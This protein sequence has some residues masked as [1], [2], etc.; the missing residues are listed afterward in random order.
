MAVNNF[1]P[2]I[3]SET[4]YSELSNQCIA[5]KHCNRDFEGDIK[6][7]GDRVKIVGIPCIELSDY[8]KG[9]S[10]SDPQTLDDDFQ[11]LEIDR[12]KC[13]NFQIDDID[14]AQS[15]PGL[16]NQAMRVA[17]NALANEAD[18]YVFECATAAG[19]RVFNEEPTVDNVL[20][21]FIEARK[22]LYKNN[23]TDS[24]DIVFEVSPDVAELLIKAKINLS[25]DNSAALENGCIGSIAGCKV[26]VTNN[27]YQEYDDESMIHRCVAR[28]KRAIA[29]AEQISELEAYRPEKRFADAVKGLHLYGAKIIYPKEIVL[30][31]FRMPHIP[32]E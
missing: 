11:T 29:F 19:F 8:K 27:V 9:Q 14:R 28:T 26:Y 15:I 17:A 1:I 12:A 2:T 18:A 10:I 7:C 30:V 32:E 16:M 6:G 5:V 25:T 23:V 13:F 31:S 4:L 20:D 24:Q 22:M 3:W 21:S